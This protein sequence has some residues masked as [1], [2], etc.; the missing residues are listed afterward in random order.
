MLVFLPRPHRLSLS[1]ALVVAWLGAAPPVGAVPLRVVTFNVQQGLRAPG[2]TSHENVAQILERLD[3]DV[4]GFQEL[5]SDTVNLPA[6]GARL[7]L[8]YNVALNDSAMQVGLLSRYPVTHYW[9]NRSGLTRPILMA[10]IEVPG[11]SQKPWVAVLHLKCCGENGG[12]EQYIR[13]V[14][15]SRLRQAL[16][17]FAAPEDPVLIMG[18]FN[19]VVRDDYS[20][21]NGRFTGIDYP[22]MAWADA[23]GYFVSESIFKLDAR[24][25]GPGGETWTWRGSSQFPPG[26]L[27]HIMANATVRAGGVAVEI[28]D[29]RK[30]AAGIP[31]LPKAGA[32]LPADSSYGSDHLPIL[33]DLELAD[34]PPARFRVSPGQDFLPVGTLP[35]EFDAME[36]VYT[37]AND[38]ETPLKWFVSE[39]A[40][41]LELSTTE[42]ITD[43]SGQ[44]SVTVSLNTLAASLTP[45]DYET[46]LLFTDRDTGSVVIRNVSLRIMSGELQVD[47]P[48]AV[49]S[50]SAETY[51]YQG[52]MS[53]VLTNGLSWSNRANGLTGTISYSARWSAEIP[54]ARGTNVVDFR[55]SYAPTSW[56]VTAADSPADPA[57][58][59]GWPDGSNGG[60]GFG[61]WQFTRVRGWA[62]YALFGADV[63]NVPPSFGGA[64]SL[65]AMG[66]GVTTTRRTF[67]RALTTEDTFHLQFDNNYIENGQSVGFAL[68]DSNGAKRLDFYFVGGE[69]FY[70]VGDAEGSRVTGVGYTDQ[71]LALAVQLVGEDGY[72][73]TAGTNVIT[74]TLAPGGPVSA[75]VATNNGSGPGTDFDFYLGN[76]RIDDSLG[77]WASDGP[78]DPAYSTGWTA[79]SR[80][81][82]GFGPWEITAVG[83]GGNAG[84]IRFDTNVW[85]VPPSFGGAFSLWA[86]GAGY[87]EA[88][89][90][91]AQAMDVAGALVLQFDNNLVEEGKLVGFSL[92]DAAGVE[93]FVFLCYGGQQIYWVADAEEAR[94]TAIP[95]TEDGLELRIE[96]TSNNTYLLTTG[97]HSVTGRLAEGGPISQLRAFNYGS[98]PGTAYDFYLGNMRLETLS[99]T[100]QEVLI[101]GLPVVREADPADLTDGL[102]NAWWLEYFGTTDGMSAAA[103][104]DG[105]GFTNGQEHALGTDPGDPASAF[106]AHAPVFSSGQ[107]SITWDAVADKT[108]RLMAATD[109]SADDWQQVGDVI[110]A[111]Q[112]GRQTFTHS[113]NTKQHFYRIELMP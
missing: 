97:S 51:R 28:F 113:T 69:S 70:R 4:I 18:D 20:Y 77:T 84:H 110:T 100:M 90:P 105:D 57:Y 47:T 86:S 7:G 92:A 60:E 75:M 40:G 38:K 87:S 102:P 67:D 2:T 94:P 17:E 54:L 111:L 36:E 35:G 26:A 33:A 44:T 32:P 48:A 68:T 109:L 5:Q 3:A 23:D 80:G 63:F 82:T 62:G 112:T 34:A 16:P 88:R 1:F 85:N 65:W 46:E 95:L 71:G 89:R 59:F 53:S 31:G 42:G 12:D 72:R 45:G 29:V 101:T 22:L 81:G 10:R 41:W 76:M 50:T 49:V 21:A 93:R 24:H 56:S 43:V 37:I 106:R 79:G 15:L 64:F 58:Q 6:L 83:V 73:L 74:G 9:I 30:D 78:N 107:V 108:Y 61:S 19:L 96:L 91:F 55:A 39:S 66:D 8:F 98:G 103:D 99:T 13:A 27:D 11:A 14:E 25:A 104:S 52:S